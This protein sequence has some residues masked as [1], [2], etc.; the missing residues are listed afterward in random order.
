[1]LGVNMAN[2]LQKISGV[3]SRIMEAV[4]LL[5]PLVLHCFL[6]ASPAKPSIYIGDDLYTSD[7][8]EQVIAE[9]VSS[10]GFVWAAPSDDDYRRMT[11]TLTK[12]VQMVSQ[13]SQEEQ[14]RL[15]VDTIPVN[16]AE[17]MDLL[18]RQVLLY[19]EIYAEQI[20]VLEDMEANPQDHAILAEYF[21][22]TGQPALANYEDALTHTAWC[23]L[24]IRYAGWIARNPEKR[25]GHVDRL[26]GM[27]Y[28]LYRIF[29]D[30]AAEGFDHLFENLPGMERINS[31]GIAWI[32][33]KLREVYIPR[34]SHIR[35]TVW[36]H[37]DCTPALRFFT[38][39]RLI[40]LPFIKEETKKR[41][42]W[43]SHFVPSM[44]SEFQLLTNGYRRKCNVMHNK[45]PQEL[46]FQ[47]VR[48]VWAEIFKMPGFNIL[49]HWEDERVTDCDFER[50]FMRPLGA[51]GA[52]ALAA[53]A[54]VAPSQPAAMA[55]QKSEAKKNRNRKRREKEQEKRRQRQRE[56]QKSSNSRK[57]HYSSNVG[58]E[59]DED[60]TAS[61]EPPVMAESEIRPFGPPISSPFETVSGPSNY[62]AISNETKHVE[63]PLESF[64]ADDTNS[65]KA[66]DKGAQPVESWEDE[67]VRDRAHFALEKKKKAQSRKVIHQLKAAQEKSASQA[68]LRRN[69]QTGPAKSSFR[70][71]IDSTELCLAFPDAFNLFLS[72]DNI[73]TTKAKSYQ[74]VFD[75]DV[76]IKQEHMDFLCNLFNVEGGKGQLNFLDMLRTYWAIEM[77]LRRREDDGVD[78]RRTV[79]KWSHR[80]EINKNVV[81]PLK[82][83]VHP[84]HA[85]SR[86]NHE[87]AH[88]LFS[89]GGFDPRFFI[90]QYQ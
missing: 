72:N 65:E 3:P 36:F 25:C 80:F 52:P 75:P 90:P 12:Y 43:S 8:A 27:F 10:P 23:N 39:G 82:K 81:I 57:P 6:L 32:L 18:V 13:K 61:T 89:G 44:P 22:K 86:F 59:D 9:T 78:L 54:N 50:S 88:A 35:H 19:Q 87:Q 69:M 79:F 60:A 15:L 37:D 17:A 67:M 14:Y 68:R 42:A 64:S 21:E 48:A 62:Q 71:G 30:I 76:I 28:N 73:C 7:P 33:C 55:D 38:Q 58:A 2:F 83:D 31:S 26:Y 49:K 84:E 53:A 66:E 29:L 63:S 45:S 74:W 16:L 1:M 70:L 85:S 51:V 47:D 11:V 34:S 56:Q 24:L 40:L 41:L 20:A 4:L 77:C 46:T 5:I